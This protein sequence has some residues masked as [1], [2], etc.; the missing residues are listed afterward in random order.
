MAP[1]KPRPSRSNLAVR[2]GE[3]LYDPPAP[4]TSTAS[5]A[6]ASSPH[7]FPPAPSR[8]ASTMY[9]PPEPDDEARSVAEA[10]AALLGG[11]AKDIEAGQETEEDR[12]KGWRRL[13]VYCRRYL[14]RLGVAATVALGVGI[15]VYGGI[16]DRQGGED[17]AE[18]SSA[19]SIPA[20]PAAAAPG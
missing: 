11:G 18:D 4:S 6:L 3:A 20:A 5:L 13:R 8:A 1:A 10:H 15:I 2:P 9:P 12:V 14:V 7:S 16:K 19:L 17:E